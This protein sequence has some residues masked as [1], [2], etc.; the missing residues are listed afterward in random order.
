MSPRKHD[1]CDEYEIEAEPD[2]LEARELDSEEAEP[3]AEEIEE[4]LRRAQVM[5]RLVFK[6]NGEFELQEV[7]V[8]KP[9]NLAAGECLVRVAWCGVSAQ[10]VLDTHRWNKSGRDKDQ[11]GDRVLG[12]HFSGRVMHTGPGHVPS[13]DDGEGRWPI[14]E[15][16]CC[17]IDPYCFVPR[18]VPLP[19]REPV[20]EILGMHRDGGMQ[21]YV[22]VSTSMLHATCSPYSKHHIPL[23]TFPMITPVA[24]AI[25]ACRRGNL[26]PGRDVVVIGRGPLALAC[27]VYAETQG[28]KVTL[29]HEGET[30]PLTA[31]EALPETYCIALERDEGSVELKSQ[32][33]QARMLVDEDAL[34]AMILARSLPRT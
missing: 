2:H 26:Q 31:R 16:S 20:L 25:R 18:E 32:G 34:L 27:C 17:V 4:Q 3:T 29:I 13:N 21:D 15:G 30:L 28:S 9:E 23:D 5:R 10:E 12:M 6:A 19:S 22:I 1:Y 14:K 8:L 11:V 33:T 7:P 24:M